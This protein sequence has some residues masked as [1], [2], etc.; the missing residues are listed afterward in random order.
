MRRDSAAFSL[1]ELLIVIAIILII[2]A[3]AV[4]NLLKSRIAANQSSAI[5]SL[6][7]LN[8]SEIAYASSYNTGYSPNLQSLGPG[9]G[10]APG[11]SA[12]GLIDSV[13][14]G[15]GN[16]STKNGYTFTYASSPDGTGRYSTYSITAAPNTPGSTGRD[17]YYTDQTSVIR[18]NSQQTAGA[19]DSPISK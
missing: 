8:E 7:T 10:G 6:R 16:T 1:I 14:A 4:P 17:Y 18:R 5:G 15:S 13:L 3:I 2:A 9:S 11:P 12:A 19:S